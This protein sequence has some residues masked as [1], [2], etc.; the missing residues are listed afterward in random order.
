VPFPAILPQLVVNN[1]LA[2]LR[3][4][5]SEPERWAVEPKVDGVRGLVA[6]LPDGRIE[7]RNRLA[8]RRQGISVSGKADIEAPRL[9]YGHQMSDGAGT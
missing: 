8:I 2:A 4:A 3:A 7:T 1:G 5:V 9:I 6:F